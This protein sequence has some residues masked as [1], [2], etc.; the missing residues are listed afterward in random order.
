MKK[1]IYDFSARNILGEEVSMNEFK[2]KFILIVNTASKCGFTPQFKELEKLYQQYRNSGFEVLGFPC[3]QFGNQ[4]PGSTEE[5]KE[6]CELN[7]GVTFRMFDKIEVNGENTHPLYK[8]LKKE[9][10]GLIGKDIKWNFT[11]FLVDTEGNIV[12]R[13]VPSKSPLKIANDIKKLISKGQN[14]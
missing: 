14:D 1:K 11:K 7:F 12:K 6:F 5:I 3:N 13:Y 10:S 8:Y 4:E 9:K 2:G